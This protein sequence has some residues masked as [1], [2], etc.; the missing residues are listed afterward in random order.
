MVS[1]PISL[2]DFIMENFLFGDSSKMI[3][4]SES[5]LE[6]GIVDSTGVLELVAFVEEEF[7]IRVED[8]DLLPENFDSIDNLSKYVEAKL[9]ETQNAAS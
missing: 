7:G 6:K 2:R 9:A 5:F 4:P 8:D 1:I 3:A